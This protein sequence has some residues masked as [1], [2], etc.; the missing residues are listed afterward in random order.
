MFVNCLG[1]LGVSETVLELSG[2]SGS[3]PN[4]SGSV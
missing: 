1:V 3:V 2:I 4:Q